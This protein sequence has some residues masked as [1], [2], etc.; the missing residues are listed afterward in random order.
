MPKLIIIER[1][2]RR[3]GGGG[4]RWAGGGIKRNNKIA[5][6][7]ARRSTGAR[8]EMRHTNESSG[9]DFSTGY[10]RQSRTNCD[11]RT[12]GGEGEAEGC[13][14]FVCARLSNIF[15][16]FV[17]L[18]DVDARPASHYLSPFSPSVPACPVHPHSPP[19][20]SRRPPR[21][22]PTHHEWGTGALPVP[23]APHQTP[24][25]ANRPPA[26][27][28]TA[29]ERAQPRLRAVGVRGGAREG[30]LEG[31]REGVREGGVRHCFRAL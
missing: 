2:S 9:R 6:R 29:R 11:P 8:N 10:Y 12:S 19:P 24:P 18:A 5:R 27:T 21:R 30:V 20:P 4:R 23:P 1:A 7:V 25:R 31:V 26:T 16:P 13:G 3:P 15:F 14:E 17:Y 28:P 22:Q